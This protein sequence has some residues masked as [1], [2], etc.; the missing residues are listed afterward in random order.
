MIPFWPLFTG[1][2]WLGFLI[3]VGVG[4][5][6]Y[7][8]YRN[9]RP[10]RQGVIDASVR[11]ETAIRDRA[12]HI[13]ELSAFLVRKGGWR[14]PPPVSAA[15]VMAIYRNSSKVLNEMREFIDRLPELRGLPEYK[16]LIRR[17]DLSGADVWQRMESY[18]VAYGNY[19]LA[20]TSFPTTFFLRF[21]DQPGADLLD[22]ALLRSLHAESIP[23]AAEDA[24]VIDRRNLFYVL[25]GGVPK[26]PISAEDLRSLVVAGVIPRDAMIAE[27]NSKEWRRLNL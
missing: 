19:Q 27:A 13:N 24:E 5:L 16:D 18:G 22:P 3:L 17:I 11:V 10:L 2:L 14:S 6:A 23:P 20:R 15:S 4:I 12:A 25:P 8:S 26:G 7:R 9:L 1:L 21:A